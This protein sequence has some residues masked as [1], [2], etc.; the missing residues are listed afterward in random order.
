MISKRRSIR[1]F[2][3]ATFRKR[4]VITAASRTSVAT[5]SPEAWSLTAFMMSTV[6]PSSSCTVRVS[7]RATAMTLRSSS[8]SFR[9]KA[10]VAASSC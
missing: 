6:L 10:S 3:S 1:P 5:I 2:R 4:A 7:L 9:D 8:I